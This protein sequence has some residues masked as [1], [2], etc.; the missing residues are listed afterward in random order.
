MSPWQYVNQMR[1]LLAAR[2]WEGNAAYEVV[3]HPT[4]V[5]ETAASPM[6]AA[7]PELIFPAALIRPLDAE[8]DDHDPRLES[9]RFEVTI[10]AVVAGGRSGRESLAGGARAA[11]QGASSGRGVLE[12]ETE[13]LA[14]LGKRGQ[15][16]GIALNL[17]SKSSSE[18][19]Y[20]EGRGF[21]SMRTYVFEAFPFSFNY[22]HPPLRLTG[23][24]LGG[25][26]VRLAWLNAPTRW[27]SRAVRISW[28][29][30]A[31]APATYGAGTAVVI[32]TAHPTTVDANVGAGQRSFAAFEAYTE[33]GIAADERY[34]SQERGTTATV[35]AT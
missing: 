26:I 15:E 6:I 9:A 27:D 25:G 5:V 1:Y 16:S 14:A 3:F 23:T 18:P 2:K 31:V 33:T 10:V 4:S 17:R 29:A 35:V 28:A 20:V 19:Q 32:G 34:S 21:V 12:L 22:Y 7:L 13:V 8:A 30:G 11:G 24:V